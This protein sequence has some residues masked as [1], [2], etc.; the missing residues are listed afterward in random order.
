[1]EVCWQFILK[2]H[3]EFLN[4][5]GF[6]LFFWF[7]V[8]SFGLFYW[9]DFF[10]SFHFQLAK[11]ENVMELMTIHGFTEHFLENANGEFIGILVG[12]ETNTCGAGKDLWS[13]FQK[14]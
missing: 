3:L 9:D 10:C 6:P 14:L 11:K 5:L 1:L 7:C 4:G 8:C 2:N 12:A 13:L